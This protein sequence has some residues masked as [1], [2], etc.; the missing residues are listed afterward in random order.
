M[1]LPKNF[2]A[3]ALALPAFAVLVAAAGMPTPGRAGEIKAYPDHNLPGLPYS[4]VVRAGDTIYVSGVLGHVPGK[5]E[6][7][8]GGVSAEA[9]QS[10]AYIKEYVELAGG[11]FENTVKCMVLLADIED[12][13]K[14]NEA[15]REYFPTNPP[16]RSTVIVPA[17]PL[18]ASVEIECNA[19]LAD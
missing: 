6:L 14:M 15:Y 9:R 16:A 10:L 4:A 1:K 7:V 17:L 12:F 5:A 8:P 11:S 18:G 2:R 13:P 19:V 3:G